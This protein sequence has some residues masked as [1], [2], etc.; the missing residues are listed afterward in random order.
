M[1]LIC[2][3]FAT[4]HGITFNPSKSKLL[5]FNID[6]KQ[7]SCIYLKGQ[8]ITVVDNEQHLGNCIATDIHDK[9]IIDI[10]S[11]LYRRSN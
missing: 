9:N 7:V 11:D 3:K 1:I 5:C 6:A 2:D 4:A 10:V 8:P